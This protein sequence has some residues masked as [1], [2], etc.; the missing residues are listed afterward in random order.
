MAKL[1]FSD[2]ALLDP[3]KSSDSNHWQSFTN[4]EIGSHSCLQSEVNEKYF[5]WLDLGAGFYYERFVI[6]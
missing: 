2:W 5:E 3:H 6:K 4:F 1:T